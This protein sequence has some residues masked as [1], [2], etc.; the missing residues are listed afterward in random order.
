MS[1]VPNE[2]AAADTQ[3]APLSRWEHFKVV[4]RK[5]IKRMGKRLIRSLADFFARQSLIEDSPI[6]AKEQFPQI[7]V[8]EENWE[9]IRSELN[10]ILKHRE[11]VPLF[12]DVSRDQK[13]ISK[14]QNW[15]T[16]ILFGFGEK[17]H[18]NCRQAPE[19]ARMLE[20]IPNLQ[21]AWFSI[22][23]PNYHIRAHRGVTKAILRC[24]L[25]LIVPRD[26]QNCTMRVEDQICVWK[27]GEALVFDDTYEHEVWN[28]TDDERVV[29]LFD[30]D[31]PMRFWGRVVHKAFIFA[32]KRTAYY[33]NPKKVMRGYEDQFE[34]AVRTADRQLEGMADDD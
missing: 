29:L 24:H 17:S 11:A 6:V 2:N 13:R 30:F 26:A 32:L 16:F 1:S 20:G 14:G 19:T 7:K 15:R 23:S 31:R 28:N 27:E 4:R 12:Q 5:K 10:E 33:K 22:L 34:A 25:G 8:L 9:V 18:K 21:T 3:P